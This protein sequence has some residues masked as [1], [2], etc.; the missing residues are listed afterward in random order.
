MSTVVEP[1]LGDEKLPSYQDH[2]LSARCEEDLRSPAPA[3]TPAYRTW[4]ALSQPSGADQLAEWI[5]KWGNRRNMTLN[6]WRT[7]Q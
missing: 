4:A 6:N 7:G 2:K 1:E 5:S 3:Y